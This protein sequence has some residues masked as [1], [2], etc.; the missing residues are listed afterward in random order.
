KQY[1]LDL[2]LFGGASIGVVP[3]M[4]WAVTPRLQ[5]GLAPWLAIAIEGMTTQAKGLEVTGATGKFDVELWALGL[6]ACVGGK[7]TEALSVF[8]CVGLR[9]GTFTTHG[10]GFEPLGNDT[11][12]PS[13][14]WAVAA[15][16]HVRLWVVP[17]FGLGLAVEALVP[18]AP[19]DIVV[20][21]GTDVLHHRKVSGIGFAITAGPV[22]RFF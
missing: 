11:D 14:W 21:M 1:T 8:S 2:A 17:T 16:G 18:L 12:V 6:D 13:P 5:F 4:T 20:T 19:R 3:S 10:Q 9:R 15:A 22:F 7:A